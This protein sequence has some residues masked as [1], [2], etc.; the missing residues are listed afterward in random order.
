MRIFYEVSVMKR[1]G[2]FLL[3]LVFVLSCGVQAFAEDVLY[4][5]MCGR[6]IPTDSRICPYCGVAVVHV[7]GDA[8]HSGA[9]T[10]AAAG[11][12]SPA[13][14]VPAADARQNAP[15]PGP[16]GTTLSGGA[17]TGV[18]VTKSPTSESVPYGGSCLFIAHAVNASSVTWYLANTDTSIIIPASEAPAYVAGLSVSGTSSDTLS[19]SGIPSWMDGYMVQACFE[20][21]GGPVY[22]DIA[23]IWTYEEARQPVCPPPCT[24]MLSWYYLWQ[25]FSGLDLG[26][27]E[28]PKIDIGSSDS[29]GYRCTLVS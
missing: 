1:I 28:C 5:R 12:S 22:T 19:L 25:Y 15:V 20:G 4:C 18:R 17:Y 9:E 8:D 21:E 13:T 24:E 2:C 27:E 14:D 23:R 16:F 11:A 10:D 29:I 7:D 26:E 6:Q 3:V